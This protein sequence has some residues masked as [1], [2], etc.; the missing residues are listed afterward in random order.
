MP[1]MTYPTRALLAVLLALLFADPLLAAGA[2]A[3]GEEDKLGFLGLKRY[4]L[5]IWTL[6]VFGLLMFVLS[7]Y[8]WPKMREGLEKREANI[9]SAL[10]EARQNAAA[11]KLELEQ[12]KRELAKAALD[13]RAIV[14][15]AR[16][17]AEALRASEREAGIRDAAIERERAKRETEALKDALLKELYDQ[18]VKLAALMSEKALRRSVSIDDHRRLLDE[19]LAD[20]KA[21]GK[22]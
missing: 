9:R 3:G 13:A 12:A 8:A 21:G 22:A 10:D 11:A 16:R 18:A 4:D 7:R 17:D 14:E 1:L 19:A 15:E 6:V 5:G 20:L 2:P